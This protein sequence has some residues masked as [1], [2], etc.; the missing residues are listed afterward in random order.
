MENKKVFYVSQNPD[1]GFKKLDA[2]L[3]QIKKMRESGDFTPALIQIC[4]EVY[5]VRNPIVI[6]QKMSNITIEPK[7]HTRLLGGIEI[8]NFTADT[9]NGKKC[10]SADIS[11][12]GDLDFTDFYVN[13]KAA[14]L[15]RY[16][17]NNT[18]APESVEDH[19]IGLCSSSK[20]FIMKEEDFEAVKKF[21][22]PENFI[23]SF[24]HFWI[25]EHTPIESIDP[26]TRKLTFKYVSRFSISPDRPAN[27]LAY[28]IEN[29]AEMFGDVNEWYYDKPTGKIYYIPE[30]ET[31]SPE[32]IAGYIP[33]TDKLITIVGE[34]DVKATDI[35]VQNFEMAYTKGDYK[36]IGDDRTFPKKHSC[37]NE[38]G[39]ASDKQSVCNA[40]GSIEFTNA[41]NCTLKNCDMYC[42]GVH[43][44]VIK[45]GCNNIT[46][47]DNSIKNIGGGGITVNGGIYGSDESTHTFG[48]TIFNNYISHCGN[49][50]FSSCGILLR[51]SH[52]NVVKNN[53]IGYVYYTGISCG[54]V[55]GYKDSISHHNTIEKNHIHHIGQGKL[56]DM[57]GIYTLGIQPGT[58]VRNNIIH[59]IN[60]SHYGGWALYTDEGSSGIL[61]ENNICYNTNNSL[62]HQHY[63]SKNIVRNNIFAFSKDAPVFYTKRGEIDGIYFRHNI[64]L[65]SGQPIFIIDYSPETPNGSLTESDKGKITELISENNIV[66]DLKREKTILIK[67]DE[68]EYDID[69]AHNEFLFDTGSI[70]MLPD[71]EDLYNF[72]FSL[73]ADSPVY[74]TGFKPIDISDVGCNR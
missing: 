63:G 68:R 25:D 52:S 65:S 29:V 24:N 35:T 32:D 28:Y 64:I 1:T 49:R 40:H 46:I 33:V 55:W 34:A 57:G 18:L 15:P 56:S 62:Y 50:Y 21:R 38:C 36:S 10:V 37:A 14:V 51:H 4:D 70:A 69:S 8:K 42:L 11:S 59:D 45:D 47:A 73:D 3:D 17:K 19:D 74:K 67:T 61:L 9:F 26:K 72:N 7:T 31:I 22:N 2:V 13:K 27:A 23:I 60:S 6:T 12:L 66:F 54:W 48:N 20:W 30:D 41:Q 71:F 44:I 39:Y 16:P 43:A 58:V 53:D 5:T